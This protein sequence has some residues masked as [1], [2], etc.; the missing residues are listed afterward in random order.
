MGEGGEGIGI[1][2]SVFVL[3]RE[4]SPRWARARDT[5][6]HHVLL[7]LLTVSMQTMLNTTQINVANCCRK[8][9][10]NIRNFFWLIYCFMVLF[11]SP[12][13]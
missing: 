10:K 4:A 3:L 8:Y 6:A 2:K 5:S 7:V 1:T 11:Y 9:F 13:S 12:F